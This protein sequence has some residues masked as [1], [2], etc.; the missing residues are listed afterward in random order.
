M[1]KMNKFFYGVWYYNDVVLSKDKDYVILNIDN[2]ESCL[3]FEMPCDTLETAKKYVKSIIKARQ[4]VGQNFFNVQEVDVEKWE[5]FIVAFET[6]DKK[7]NAYVCRKEYI[8][9]IEDVIYDIGE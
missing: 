6:E 7:T 9:N 1:I 4:S 2:A 8:L 3:T 5:E